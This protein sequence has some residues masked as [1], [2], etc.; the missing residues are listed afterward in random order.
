VTFSATAT[1][2]TAGKLFVSQ[3]P[4]TSPENGEPFA[5]QPEIQLQDA[6]GNPLT[7][8]GI[9][10]KAEFA[11]SQ[12]GAT[13]GGNTTAITDNGRATFTDLGI[14]G[15]VGSYSLKFSVPNRSD[16][17][18]TTSGTI[19]L[20][21]GP[22]SKIA[23]NL[24]GPISGTAGGP[25]SPAPS[26][27][28]TDQSGN[29]VSGVLVTFAVTAGGGGVTGASQPTNSSGI[30][31]VGGWTLGTTAGANA[32]T[33]SATGLTGSPVTFNATGSAGAATTISASSATTLNATAG[34]AVSP[35]PSVLVTDGVNPVAGVMVTF[36]VTGGGGSITGSADVP[37]GPD[38]IATV[39]GWTLGTTAGANTLTASVTGLTGSPVTFDATGSVG[40]A[41]TISANSSTTLS[42]TAGTA[43]SPAPSV[44]V[45]DGVNPVAG[46]TVTFAVTGGGGSISGSAD[47]LTGPDGIATVDGWTLGP[48]AGDNTLTA[49]AVGLTGNPV[50]FTGT[51]S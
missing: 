40:A 47:V 21:A 22:A 29:P 49:T 10:V 23:S 45:T 46:V 5:Q 1:V 36:A 8:G 7:L 25:A 2:G 32:L 14:T 16:I 15:V 51:G 50:T 9:A 43:V 31:T 3:Q 11:T 42:A 44:L 20:V 38:G 30:A 33:A 12:P 13:L 6:S 18:G 35:A 37:T 19:T 28:V 34:T 41:T 39:G 24:Q 27:L 17:T 4:S 26:V 48:V